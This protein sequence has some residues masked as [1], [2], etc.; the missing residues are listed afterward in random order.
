MLCQVKSKPQHWKESSPTQT[1]GSSFL[2]YFILRTWSTM[3]SG[4]LQPTWA[5]PSSHRHSLFKSLCTPK[6][7]FFLKRFNNSPFPVASLSTGRL[8]VSQKGLTPQ[9]KPW[10][11]ASIAAFPI[12]QINNS[13]LKVSPMWDTERRH[14]MS[15]VWGQVEGCVMFAQTPGTFSH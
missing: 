8:Q 14:F 1:V 2:F 9:S 7:V 4:L 3:S 13:F 10:L 11:V 5:N 15:I 6:G 12:T